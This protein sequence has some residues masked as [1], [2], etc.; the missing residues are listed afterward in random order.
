MRVEGVGRNT[1]LY[2]NKSVT[3]GLPHQ[4]NNL[5]FTDDEGHAIQQGGLRDYL[6]RSRAVRLNITFNTSFCTSMFQTRYQT[7]REPAM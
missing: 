3:L 6:R 1:H 7:Q 4:V 2:L 5:L